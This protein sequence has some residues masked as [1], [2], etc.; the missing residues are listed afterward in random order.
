MKKT[1]YQE[2][3]GFTLT[4]AILD[5]IPVLFF[6]IGAGILASR[7]NSL[8]FRIGIILVIVAGSLKALWKFVIAL[9]H[10]DVHFLSHQMRY[11]MPLGF[12]LALISLLINQW[13]MEAVIH[14]IMTFPSFL[15]LIIGILGIFVLAWHG[16]N[17]DV[18]DAKANWRE[19]MI[20]GIV[21]L[22][23]MLCI[24]F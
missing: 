8:F 2:F 14:H 19:Q 17:Y 6:S 4:M 3:E 13:S 18:R 21:Q 22:C 16:K 5:L 23:I 7:F 15:F 1:N 24:L 12:L 20:N 10:K 11:L 9:V